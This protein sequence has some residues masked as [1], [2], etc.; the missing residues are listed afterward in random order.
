MSD[1]H[2]PQGPS[3]GTFWLTSL[4]APPAGIVLLWMRRGPSVFTKLGGTLLL[5]VLTLAYSYFILTRFFDMRI[6]M[7]GSGA[8]TMISFGKPEDHFAELEKA[9]AAQP[10]TP[11]PVSQAVAAPQPAK[12]EPAPASAAAQPAASRASA[13]WA[14]FRGPGRKGVYD[15]TPILTNW[16]AGGLRQLWKQPV[17]GGYASFAIADGRAYTIEQRRD[18]EVVAAY[19]VT[20]GRELWTN[21]WNAH[22]QESMGGNGPR[23]TPVWDDGRIYALGAAGELRCLDA[24]T[25]KLLWNKNIL[26]DNDAENITW[27]MAA[28]PLIVDGKV[29][30]QPG[31][32]RGRSV[33]AYNKLT[34][35]AVWRSQN[36]AQSYTSPMVATVAGRRQIL[37]VSAERM[38]GLSI[39][40]GALLWSY[41]WRT[42]YNINSSQPV[43]VDETHVLVTAG[44][45]HGAALVR[46]TRDGNSFRAEAGW[47]NNSLKGRFNS[48]VLHNG[49][50]Y[51]FD[52]SIFACIDAR[53]G[54]RKWKGGRYGYGQV[55]LAG[56]HL[57]ITTE[58][59]D[60]V[61]VRATPERHEEVARFSAI[62]GKTWNHPAIA[63]GVLLVR[64]TREMAAFRLA[65]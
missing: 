8:P 30:V 61:L 16:P 15:Q 60:V 52:E 46:V 20:T 26:A 57:V 4:L 10:A 49:Y 22:F 35:E 14:D 23:A 55:I 36:D 50:I 58:T 6:E 63:D 56:D 47:E 9:R 53:T 28:S 59:G 42:A 27:G 24:A 34:G 33:V 38:M 12:S 41:P 32:H 39:E 40:D 29:I 1:A 5:G 13:Y 51:G 18:Q 19:D 17:G 44:Y 64:N 43:V 37:T 65:P 45:D 62:E 25:G 7:A 48:P 54:Q 21:A 2:T 3:K 31:G 11:Q